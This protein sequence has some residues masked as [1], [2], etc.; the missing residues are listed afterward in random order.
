MQ[1]GFEVCAFCPFIP[2]V[3]KYER[4][5]KGEIFSTVL[6][7]VP[8]PIFVF[9]GRG[10]VKCGAPARPPRLVVPRGHHGS[11]Q[12]K[13]FRTN[14]GG[15]LYQI[16]VCEH[17]SPKILIEDINRMSRIRQPY[18]Q[19]VRRE[20]DGPIEAKWARI[21]ISEPLCHQDNRIA[22]VGIAPSLPPPFERARRVRNETWAVYNH[23]RAAID[24]DVASVIEITAEAAADTPAPG[25]FGLADLASGDCCGADRSAIS[26]ALMARG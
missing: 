19:L 26:D 11:E 18:G 21:M 13:V 12:W 15:A 7:R 23:Q 9:S 10:T 25:S 17:R 16:I 4:R 5:F 1:V 6:D 8:Q 14:I 2:R 20:L 22:V 3:D 24:P